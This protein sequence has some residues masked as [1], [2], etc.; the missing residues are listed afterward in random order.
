MSWAEEDWTVGLP[1][2]ALQKVKELQ[3]QQE[4]LN[5]ERQQ[6]QLQLDSTQTS[7]NKQTVKYEEV[8]GELQCVQREL[9]GAR[10]EV[11][12]GVCAQER[13][14]QDLQVKQA[15]VCSLE[16]QLGSARTLTH[17][18]EK[19]VKRLEAELEKLQTTS[20]SGDSM[21]FS[22][23]CWSM[24]SPR[25]HNGGRQEDRQGQREEG[26]NKALHVRVSSIPKT[27]AFSANQPHM[28]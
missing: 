8:C 20:S 1:G 28:F 5:R 16:G 17:T 14:S 2:R 23:P 7:L 13:L 18:L 6:K 27:E 10:E 4:R 11:Q 25:Y 9:Q 22:N 26:D 24:T 15:Q 12:A 19:E 3:V 21:L